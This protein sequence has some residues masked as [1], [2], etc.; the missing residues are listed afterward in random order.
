MSIHICILLLLAL[1]IAA[2][3]GSRLRGDARQRQLRGL[4][5]FRQPPPASQDPEPTS[6]SKETTTMTE[7]SSLNQPSSAEGSIYVNQATPNCINNVIGFDVKLTSSAQ[8][9]VATL[10]CIDDTRQ[11]L[12]RE[13]C[14]PQE[15]FIPSNGGFTCGVSL[16]HPTTFNTVLFR[17]SSIQGQGATCTLEL[18]ERSK[19]EDTG[20]IVSTPLISHT[21]EIG[22]CA[23]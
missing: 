7:N 16:E 4:L 13:S 3:E 9:V 19:S 18:V 23:T 12:K 22:A 20:Y 11:V 2:A 21:V 8:H 15:N 5:F 14:F 1:M 17:L 10:K 6:P